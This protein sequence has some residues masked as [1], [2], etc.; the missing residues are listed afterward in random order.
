MDLQ[1]FLLL[2]TGQAVIMTHQMER[3]MRPQLIR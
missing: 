2:R 3:T 1:Q